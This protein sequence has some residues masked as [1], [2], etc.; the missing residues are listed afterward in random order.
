MVN[1]N[2]W[3]HGHTAFS[4][5]QFPPEEMIY[6]KYVHGNLI[7]YQQPK[8]DTNTPVNLTCCA[9]PSLIRAKLELKRKS[10]VFWVLFIYKDERKKLEFPEMGGSA[11]P[12]GVRT[13]LGP[14]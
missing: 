3:R 5:A 12:G 14:L 13:P 2:D 1:S 10:C 8:M 7:K 9:R 4:D 11:P 6:M